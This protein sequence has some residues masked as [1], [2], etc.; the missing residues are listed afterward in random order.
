C[1][2]NTCGGSNEH[3]LAGFDIPAQVPAFAD[4]NNT[5]QTSTNFYFAYG[6]NNLFIGRRSTTG[7][8]SYTAFAGAL[9][10]MIAH[11]G[12]ANFLFVDG[13]VKW[14][15]NQTGLWVLDT[16]SYNADKAWFTGTANQPGPPSTGFDYDA[17]GILGTATA[18]D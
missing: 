7:P 9:P 18:Y 16:A 3:P 11:Q 8:G 10:K 14:S 6:N 4:S 13:H 1:V 5:Q 15:H 2:G 12:G 17:D